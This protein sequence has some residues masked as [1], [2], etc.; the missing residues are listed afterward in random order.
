MIWISF[1][2]NLAVLIPVLIALARRSP[3]MDAAFGPD[4]PARRI[5]AS[6]Y[7]AIVCASALAVV[8]PAAALSIG[9][10]LL[11]LQVL[12][13]AIT[14]PALG[15]ANPVARVNAAVAAVHTGTLASIWL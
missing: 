6:F 8:V 9:Q 11:P 15:W 12:Y 3:A 2:L 13:K 7:L 4:T 1:C 10:T 14:L 5:T